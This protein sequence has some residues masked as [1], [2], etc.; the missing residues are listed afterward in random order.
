VNRENFSGDPVPAEIVPVS[1]L[2]LDPDVCTK[3]RAA[4]PAAVADKGYHNRITISVQ[5][6]MR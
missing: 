1:Q 5:Y 6:Q 4:F 3:T 2:T